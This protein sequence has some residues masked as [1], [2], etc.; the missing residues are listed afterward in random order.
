MKLFVVEP[1]GTGGMIHYAYQLCTALAKEGVEVTLVTAHNYE[2]A[3]FPHNFHVEKRMRLW[4]MFDPASS[5]PP[6]GFLA[7]YGVNF[8]GPFAGVCAEFGL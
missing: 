5:Q 4:Q 7:G 6:S 3:D 8:T 1:L 2:L